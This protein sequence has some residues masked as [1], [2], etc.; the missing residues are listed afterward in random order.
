MEVGGGY[1]WVSAVVTANE[2]REERGAL[3]HAFMDGENP[4]G[5]TFACQDLHH[6]TDFGIRLHQVPES[7]TRGWDQ[8]AKAPFGAFFLSSLSVPPPAQ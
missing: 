7:H 8:K 2:Q 5:Q 1:V 4:S 3:D 6:F